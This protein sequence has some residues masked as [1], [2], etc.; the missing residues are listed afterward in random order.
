MNYVRRN[1]YILGLLPGT[2]VTAWLA[3]GWNDITWVQKLL[4]LNFIVLMLHEFEEYYW[5]GGFPWICNEVLMP[6][7]GGPP[8][9]YVLNRNNAAFVNLLAWVFYL[10][11]VFFPKFIWLGLGQILFG[12]IGQVIEHGVIINRK[13]KTLYN[14]GLVAVVLGHVPLGILYLMEVVGQGAAQWWDLLFGV[15]YLG[16]FSGVIMQRIAFGPLASPTSPYPFSAEEMNRNDRERHLRRAGIQ[17]R[18][19]S[20]ATGFSSLA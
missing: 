3:W 18:P 11:P 12:L 15:L 2:L 5:P 6:K 17:P 1:W 16:F 8:D 14:P 19:F 9:R 4:A 7:A 10:V 20:S 13:L